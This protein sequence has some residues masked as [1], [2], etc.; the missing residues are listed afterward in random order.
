MNAHPPIPES[1][2]TLQAS[3][4]LIDGQFELLRNLGR[5]GMG[6]VYLA[7]Y[8]GHCQ[9]AVKLLGA[10]PSGSSEQEFND[11]FARECRVLMA[12]RHPAIVHAF[13]HGVNGDSGLRYL[14]MEYVEGTTLSSLRRSMGRPLT[15]IEAADMLLPIADALCYCHSEGVF[16]RDISPQNILVTHHQG[17]EMHAKL[18]DFG[19]S[20]QDDS[21]HLTR[22]VIF[23]NID[24]QPLERFHTDPQKD[25]VRM[26]ETVDVFALAAVAF[27]L[28]GG[29]G[30]T[31]ALLTTDQKI[32]AVPILED[33]SEEWRTLLTTALHPDRRERLSSMVEFRDRLRAVLSTRVDRPG[34]PEATPYWAAESQDSPAGPGPTP[35][36]AFQMRTPSNSAI[37]RSLAPHAQAA[38]LWTQ[39][40][41]LVAGLVIGMFAAFGLGLMF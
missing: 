27:Y 9:V 11:R 19:A 34:P 40:S 29:N 14:V 31:G 12:L 26:G 18:V 36:L 6:T 13:T 15:P 32:G 37:Q 38:G 10:P 21:Q 35:S 3:T 17:A 2:Q 22:G 39:R 33:S 41:S 28:T 1:A 16:H 4:V 25:P 7:R 23:G 8:L 30:P 20:W 24:F 5:G